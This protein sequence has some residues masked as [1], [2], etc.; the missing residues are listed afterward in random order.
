MWMKRSR[1]QTASRSFAREIDEIELFCQFLTVTWIVEPLLS[2]TGYLLLDS[3]TIGE[4]T[5]NRSQRLRLDKTIPSCAE[6]FIYTGSFVSRVRWV[7]TSSYCRLRDS[8]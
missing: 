4:I 6:W 5:R 7:N 3:K 8:E 1:L 2:G